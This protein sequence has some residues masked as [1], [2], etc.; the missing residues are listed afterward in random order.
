MEEGRRRGVRGGR[1]CKGVVVKIWGEGIHI[2]LELGLKPAAQALGGV[3][4]RVGSSCCWQSRV[5]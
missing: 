1:Y 4:V 5:R 3:K 2:S